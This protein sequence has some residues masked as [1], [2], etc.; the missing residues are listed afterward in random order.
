MVDPHVHSYRVVCLLWFRADVLVIKLSNNN[1]ELV[2][3][4]V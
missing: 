4:V 2:F 3:T 1:V